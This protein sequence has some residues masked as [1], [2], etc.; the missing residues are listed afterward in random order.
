MMA[1]RITNFTCRLRF[2]DFLSIGVGGHGVA[3][4]DDEWCVL[5]KYGQVVDGMVG[6][7]DDTFVRRQVFGRI[8]G[9]REAVPVHVLAC[10]ADLWDIGIVVGDLRSELVQSVHEGKGG[11]LVQVVNI[12]LIR[13]GEEQNLTAADGFGNGVE[14]ADRFIDDEVGHGAVDL[15][16]ELDKAGVDA[17]LARFP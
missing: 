5:G 12:G 4:V 9:R 13:E 3:G 14:S 15:S 8:V 1:G 11:G 6:R 7:D 2:P 17:V 10:R 16:G